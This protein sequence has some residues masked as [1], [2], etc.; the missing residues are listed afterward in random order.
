MTTATESQP[1]APDP[2]RHVRD[3]EHLHAPFG[4][5]AFGRRAERLARVFG[6]PNYILTQTLFVIAWIVLN[7]VA[8]S[9]RWDPYPF[10]LLNLAFFDPG[11]LRGSADPACADAAGRPRQG[12]RGVECSPPR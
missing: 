8:V 7:A 5:D 11:G 10:I 9:L 4:T 1:D 12:V 3:H 2:L 6:T